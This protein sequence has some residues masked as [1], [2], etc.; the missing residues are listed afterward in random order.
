MSTMTD[1]TPIEEFPDS[2][3]AGIYM[4]ALEEAANYIREH[5]NTD[6]L[7]DER[8]LEITKK[9]IGPAPDYDDSTNPHNMSMTQIAF[10]EYNLAKQLFFDRVF[11]LVS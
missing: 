5:Q 8:I 11:T 7:H 6:V 2:C 1:V 10:K 4:Q 9:A 3:S